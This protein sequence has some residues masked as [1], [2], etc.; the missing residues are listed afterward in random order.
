MQNYYYHVYFSNGFD[1]TYTITAPNAIVAM[2]NL[3]AEAR[4]NATENDCQVIRY[5]LIDIN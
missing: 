2:D 3:L 1:C 4:A 5:V